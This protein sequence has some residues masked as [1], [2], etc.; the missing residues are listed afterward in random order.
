MKVRMGLVGVFSIALVMAGCGTTGQNINGASPLSGA[1]YTRQDA[2]HDREIA[3]ARR[4]AELERLKRQEAEWR[5]KEAEYKAQKAQEEAE[6]AK[7]DAQ[8]ERT[9]EKQ[10][11]AAGRELGPQD[12]S[13]YAEYREYVDGRNGT[14]ARVLKG[15]SNAYDADGD[16]Y[17]DGQRGA[18]A[19][20][21]SYTG[22][23]QGNTTVNN[24]Y[25]DRPAQ[26]YEPMSWD[27]WYDRPSYSYLVTFDPWF[28]YSY[29]IYCDWY[30]PCYWGYGYSPYFYAYPSIW[31][32]DYYGYWGYPYVRHS[33]WSSGYYWGY[34]DGYRE[35]YYYGGGYTPQASVPVAPRQVDGVR[36]PRAASMSGYG[37]AQR[38]ASYASEGRSRTQGA[39]VGY[40]GSG[41][42]NS[43]SYR[44][45]VN[46][47]RT[48]TR[49]GDVT[50]VY[51]S[52]DVDG[53]VVAP[54]NPSGYGPRTRTRASSTAPKEPRSEYT[55][56]EP[57]VAPSSQPERD[58]GTR[59]R[60]RTVAPAG[61][62]VVQPS[63]RA[64]AWG[65]DPAPAPRTRT[66]TPEAAPAPSYNSAPVASPGSDGPARSG[67]TTTR[68]RTR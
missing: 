4:E 1:Y 36:V 45:G 26:R 65:S 31:T 9:V 34:N 21:G 37:R 47:V 60:V 2:E 11:P 43:D 24:Y 42:Y 53:A 33:A 35:G 44:Q 8:R 28:N 25:I 3:L 66:R 40:Y 56:V 67:G 48:R 5:A 64:S 51:G 7:R 18:S 23:Q 6:K 63:P 10:P 52:R 59:T 61:E 50:P 30:G 32:Y 68:T 15:T 46:S 16:R 55:P 17:S 57:P 22:G 38:S 20:A 19:R 41:D 62:P 29:R 12:F 13:S 39:S 49:A 54:V 58:G 14:P 27:Y